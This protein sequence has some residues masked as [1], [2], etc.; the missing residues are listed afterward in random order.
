MLAP[1]ELESSP[2]MTAL[3]DSSHL[4]NEWAVDTKV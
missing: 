4:V 1:W 3:K 2:K